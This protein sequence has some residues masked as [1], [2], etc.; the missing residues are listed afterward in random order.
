[1][2]D[3]ERLLSYNV[4]HSLERHGKTFVQII[5]QWHEASAGQGPNQLERCRYNYNMFNFISR[6]G[7]HG[8]R[9]VTTF[10]P[11]TSA[12]IY[13]CVKRLSL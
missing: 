3:A 5:A 13:L 8:I 9:I 1:M 6:S 11:S 12:G 7:C 10:P 2:K 4:V